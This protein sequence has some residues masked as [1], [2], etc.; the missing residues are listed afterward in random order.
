MAAKVA[1][2][3]QVGEAA[4][5]LAA[6]VGDPQPRV[7]AASALAIGEVGEAEHADVLLTLTKDPDDSVSTAAARGL[8]RLEKRLDRPLR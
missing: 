5:P 4:D 6:L 1:R 2:K 8:E 3:H 7:R